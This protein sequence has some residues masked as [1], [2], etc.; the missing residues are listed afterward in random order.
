MLSHAFEDAPLVGQE[1]TPTQA[2]LFTCGMFFPIA[3]YF[4]ANSEWG[5]A[6]AVQSR[7]WPVA[8]G[9]ITA[10]A[11]SQKYFLPWGTAYK[12]EIS[13]RY[14]V[15]GLEYTADRV[16]FGA[17][18]SFDQGFIGRLA[19]QY[20]VG[21]EVN[22]HY[23]PSEPAVAVIDTSNETARNYARADKLRAQ[24][25]SL[26]PAVVWVVVGFRSMLH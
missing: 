19:E 6:R 25:F 26:L 23:D 2:L 21:G 4:Y 1:F 13:Y 15:A 7:E 24:V 18:R 5:M 3:A 16:T 10:N 17:P 22:V 11:I 20:R 12:L 9:I 8:S 14:D